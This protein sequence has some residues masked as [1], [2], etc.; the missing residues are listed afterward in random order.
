MDFSFNEK[1][2]IKDLLEKLS[3]EELYELFEDVYYVVQDKV[4]KMIKNKG[5]PPAVYS[6]TSPYNIAAKELQRQ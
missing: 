3:D 5:R 6:N 4:E 1:K 2:E